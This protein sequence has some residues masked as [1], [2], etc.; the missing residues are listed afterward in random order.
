M[1]A[2]FVYLKQLRYWELWKLKSCSIA[3]HHLS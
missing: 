1:Y 3:C 2:Y